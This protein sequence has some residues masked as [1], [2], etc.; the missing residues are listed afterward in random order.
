[1]SVGPLL[2]G[3]ESG[4]NPLLHA[5]AAAAEGFSVQF[6]TGPNGQPSAAI[7]TGVGAQATFQNT[8]GQ[9]VVVTNNSPGIVNIPIDANGDPSIPAGIDLSVISTNP[10]IPSTPTPPPTSSG[11]RY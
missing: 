2:I 6:V 8:E 1:M 5:C 4:L 11:G 7:L 3:C 9:V 10:S